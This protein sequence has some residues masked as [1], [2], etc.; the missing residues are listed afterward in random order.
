MSCVSYLDMLFGAEPAGALME[1]R[2]QRPGG[3][4]QLWHPVEERRTL[5][6]I[7]ERLGRQCDAFIGVGP[8]RWREGCRDAVERC[9]ALWADL[10]TADSR[11]ALIDFSPCPSIT[12]SSGSGLHAYFAI[13]PPAPPDELE[14]ANRRL[15]HALGGDMA[16]TDAARILRPPGTFNHKSAPA[17]VEVKHLEAVVYTLEEVVG[18]L[19]DPPEPRR[20]SRPAARIDRG[21]PLLS[22]PPPTYVEALSGRVVGRDGKCSCPLPDHEDRTPSCHVYDDPERGFYCYGCRRGGT[23]IDLGAALYGLDP[24]GRGYHEIR[25]RLLDA[26]LLQEAA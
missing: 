20:E 15:A 16:A 8:R 26:L 7:L 17:P 25:R 19:P 13:W 22:I 5:P 6:P 3:M 12:I 10:D 21:D 1:V 4:V 18:H 24:R 9:H 11:R 23:V 14:S 2:Y